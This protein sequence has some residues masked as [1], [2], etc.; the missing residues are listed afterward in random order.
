MILG[1]IFDEEHD[2]DVSFSRKITVREILELRQF[3]DYSDISFPK[4]S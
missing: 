2:G 3:D 4:A 1:V